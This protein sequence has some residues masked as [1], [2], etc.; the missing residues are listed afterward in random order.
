MSEEH[1][2]LEAD[3]HKRVDRVET[4]QDELRKEVRALTADVSALV[5][6]V[7]TIDESVK[8]IAHGLRPN[9]GN[10]IAAASLALVMGAGVFTYISAEIKHLDRVSQMRHDQ[11][12]IIETDI[13]EYIEKDALKMDDM[14]KRMTSHDE[15]LL[16]IEREIYPSAK[17]R[18]G[19]PDGKTK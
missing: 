13:Q 7:K 18:E 11:Q 10:W 19:R 2:H 8:T 17:Y 1:V 14:I 5:T 15:R 9:V 12:T 16:N 4:G 3:I 6:A